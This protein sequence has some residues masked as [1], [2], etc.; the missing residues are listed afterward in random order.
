MMKPIRKP[1]LAASLALVG[2]LGGCAATGGQVC[3]PD[4]L[5]RPEIRFDDRGNILVIDDHVFFSKEASGG[6]RTIGSGG[7]GCN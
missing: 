5:T 2:L 7:C 4:P 1:A 6:S 3:R